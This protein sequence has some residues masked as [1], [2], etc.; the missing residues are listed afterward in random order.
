M[1]QQTIHPDRGPAMT[2]KLVAL[3]LADLCVTKSLSRPHV[4][5][6]NPFRKVFRT[7]KYCPERP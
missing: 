5:N 3:L 4:S 1:D 7:L 2:S 6:D